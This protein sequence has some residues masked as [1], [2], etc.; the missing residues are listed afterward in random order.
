VGNAK[1]RW[2]GIE[3]GHHSLS[4]EP[5]SNKE[6]QEKLTKINHWFCQQLA[7]L[8]QRLTETPEPGGS[9]NLLDNTVIM[10][11]NELGKGNS[12]T[13]DNVPFVLL[14]GG[15][16][17]QMGRSLRLDRT[18]HNRLL[19]SLAHGFGHNLKTFGNPDFCDAGPLNLS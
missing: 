3:E 7:Y 14:G 17:F 12:H 5:D 9:G 16:G 11:T 15:L 13:L 1:M 6:A 18:P 2:L 8:A 19:L 10:W 4:H